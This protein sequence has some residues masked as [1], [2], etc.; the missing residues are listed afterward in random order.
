MNQHRD[1]DAALAK[2]VS[3]LA[4]AV[5]LIAARQEQTTPDDQTKTAGQRERRRHGR[6]VR[7]ADVLANARE[8]YAGREI[9]TQR[10]LAIELGIS[11]GL[12]AKVHKR[13]KDERKAASGSLVYVFLDESGL[14]GTAQAPYLPADAL[15]SWQPA[16]LDE[17]TS[18]A[19]NDAMKMV[20]QRAQSNQPTNQPNPH[21][22]AAETAS[23]A[24]TPPEAR[25][26]VG[27]SVDSR[28]VTGKGES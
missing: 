26:L 3:A 18:A 16:T 27:W 12:A 22:N 1:I 11:T 5:Q 28:N 6:R 24:R 25:R 21:V 19:F 14:T 9:P 2:A 10:P 8:R 13:L 7:F 23:G 20:T 17:G 15:A 4:E